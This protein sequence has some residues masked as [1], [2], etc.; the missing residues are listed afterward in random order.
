M[1]KS[2]LQSA[3]PGLTFNMQFSSAGMRELAAFDTADGLYDC[4][5]SEA[6]ENLLLS[7]SGD[8]GIRLYDLAAPP[9][10]NPLRMFKEHTHEV[11][12]LGC[13]K[14]QP[15]ALHSNT[16]EMFCRSIV[17]RMPHPSCLIYSKQMCIYSPPW[18]LF[19]VSNPCASASICFASWNFYTILKHT[20]LVSAVLLL[21]RKP[22]Q[23]GAVPVLLMG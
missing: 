2:A 17:A 9:Q 16:Q 4:C 10:L 7:A 23:Q 12:V 22:S 20:S 19:Q 21:K 3:W 5:W 14:E 13:G 15:P 11:S 18:I 6:N 1:A 8:G